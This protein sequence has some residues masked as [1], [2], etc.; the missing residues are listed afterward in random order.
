MTKRFLSNGSCFLGWSRIFAVVF[1]VILCGCSSSIFHEGAYVGNGSGYDPQRPTATPST[2]VPLFASR[3]V[4]DDARNRVAMERATGRPVAARPATV[5]DVIAWRQSGVRDE[6]V[7]THIRIHGLYQP[8]QGQDVLTLQNHGVS[9]EV[10][11]TMKEHPYPKVDAP[12][13][14]PSS[15]GSSFTRF[16]TNPDTNPGNGVHESGNTGPYSVGATSPSVATVA[17]PVV[18]SGDGKPRIQSQGIQ[19]QESPYFP[20]CGSCADG[21]RVGGTVVDGTVVDGMVVEGVMADGTTVPLDGGTI[22]CDEG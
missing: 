9:V 7:M 3:E 8:L 14:P 15:L 21:M 11:R 18:S 13:P 2:S 19:G 4:K 12:A 5:N 16:S 17:P 20:A 1:S 10:I 22:Y 6:N